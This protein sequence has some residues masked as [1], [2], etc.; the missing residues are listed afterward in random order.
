[1]VLP[2]EVLSFLRKLQDPGSSLCECETY[3]VKLLDYFENKALRE[4]LMREIRSLFRSRKEM[5]LFIIDQLASKFPNTPDIEPLMKLAVQYGDLQVQMSARIWLNTPQKPSLALKRLYYLLEED[6]ELRHPNSSKKLNTLLQEIPKSELEEALTVLTKDAESYP[7]L[8]FCT[9]QIPLEASYRQL[10]IKKIQTLEQDILSQYLRE[11]QDSPNF[12]TIFQILLKELSPKKCFEIFFRASNNGNCYELLGDIAKFLSEI[13]ED[14]YFLSYLTFLTGRNIRLSEELQNLAFDSVHNLLAPLQNTGQ[15]GSQQISQVLKQAP[16]IFDKS[17][18]NAKRILDELNVVLQTIRNPEDFFIRRNA[19]IKAGKGLI[20]LVGWEICC[21]D[22]SAIPILLGRFKSLKQ[23]HLLQW[24][25]HHIDTDEFDI[26]VQDLSSIESFMQLFFG[27]TKIDSVEYIRVLLEQALSS[28]SIYKGG[29]E[30]YFQILSSTLEMLKE[31][32]R[33]A[34]LDLHC[35]VLK[36]ITQT[37]DDLDFYR[38]D[39]EALC[40]IMLGGNWDIAIKYLKER[41]L[42]ENLGRLRRTLLPIIWAYLG[43]PVPLPLLARKLAQVFAPAKEGGLQQITHYDEIN[44]SDLGKLPDYCDNAVSELLKLG[45]AGLDW[46]RYGSSIETYIK[47]C[48]EY[49]GTHGQGQFPDQKYF[50]RRFRVPL[51]VL[52]REPDESGALAYIY[53]YF[54]E[55]LN[56]ADLLMLRS[57]LETNY[58]RNPLNLQSFRDYVTN[59]PM[60]HPCYDQKNFILNRLDSPDN[61]LTYCLERCLYGSAEHDLNTLAGQIK[62]MYESTLS[63]PLYAQSRGINFH[64]PQEDLEE[65]ISKLQK[66]IYYECIL[67]YEAFKAMIDGAKERGKAQNITFRLEVIRRQQNDVLIIRV[68]D[69][70]H[71]WID[72][73]E[74]KRDLQ[75]LFDNPSGQ[76]KVIV[77][78]FKKYCSKFVVEESHFTGSEKERYEINR[79]DILAGRVERPCVGMKQSNKHSFDPRFTG[80]QDVRSGT[81]YTFKI[82]FWQR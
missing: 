58:L 62:Q 77:N 30:V 3:F 60:D 59:L 18:S 76:L 13:P 39:V 56:G 16:K 51:D 8:L 53:K 41:M 32:Q 1:M 64:C 48:E 35:K 2:E 65:V 29:G 81:I 19:G 4:A 43:S 75:E 27:T 21:S 63:L 17:A 57:Y 49:S 74:H 78:C 66:D 20:N 54:T 68:G 24:I 61:E 25:L 11:N 33:E 50:K 10:I 80:G 71:G 37:V 12:D 31:H 73:Y 69:D 38:G 6:A 40:S 28:N 45:E 67:W 5:Q 55:Y 47:E 70:G 22:K 82:P 52:F 79:Y 42:E 44:D 15:G 46:D 7:Q 26:S 34:G 72:Q 23:S 14:E 36:S 9:A